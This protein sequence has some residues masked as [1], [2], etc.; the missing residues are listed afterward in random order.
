[1]ELLFL[2]AFYTLIIWIIISIAT[3]WL[4]LLLKIILIWLI[5]YFITKDE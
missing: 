3:S 2:L 1:M 4:V 5:L